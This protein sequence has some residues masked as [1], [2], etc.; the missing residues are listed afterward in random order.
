METHLNA[1]MRE[2]EQL[3][4]SGETENSLQSIRDVLKE[5]PNNLRALNLLGAMLEVTGDPLGAEACFRRAVQLSP[6]LFPSNLHLALNL[7][8]QK[9]WNEA[10]EIAE[11]LLSINQVEPRLW[12]LLARAE[13]ASGNPQ[14]ALGYLN[15]SLS[16]NADQP[17]L[18]ILHD[19]LGEEILGK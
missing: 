7:G 5:N 3:F 16:L 14:I 18:R 10:K 13:K 4:N 9:R 12:S 1:Q 2:I 15:R 19:E 6:S 8:T 11:K 17:E